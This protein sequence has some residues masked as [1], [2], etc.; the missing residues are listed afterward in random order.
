VTPGSDYSSYTNDQGLTPVTPSTQITTPSSMFSRKP[1]Y[2]S[3]SPSPP[4]PNFATNLDSAFPPF[5]SRYDGNGS[6]SGQQSFMR[7]PPS[8]GANVIQ[9]MNGVADGPFS[10]GVG[11]TLS[12]NPQNGPRIRRPS[13]ERYNPNGNWE[14]QD[15]NRQLSEPQSLQSQTSDYS[16]PS[17]ERK[18]SREKTQKAINSIDMFLQDMD[19]NTQPASMLA[20]E[21]RSNTFP[22]DANA[23]ARNP[24]GGY[25]SP[26]LSAAPNRAEFFSDAPPA[27]EEQRPTTSTMLSRSKTRGRFDAFKDPAVHN[28]FIPVSRQQPLSV[29]PPVQNGNQLKPVTEANSPDHDPKSPWFE[30][31][32]PSPLPPGVND[33]S[34]PSARAR[35]RTIARPNEPTAVERFLGNRQPAPALP[36]QTLR[37]EESSSRSDPSHSPSNSS[38]SYASSDLSTAPTSAGSLSRNV[39]S[40]SA[41]SRKRGISRPQRPDALPPPNVTTHIPQPLESPIDPAVHHLRQ[42]LDP[43]VQMASSST[44]P[45]SLLSDSP[46]RLRQGPRPEIYTH[47]PP[48]FQATVSKGEC[49]GCGTHIYGKSVKAAD[50]RLTGRYHKECFVCRTCQAPF[51]SAEFYVHENAPY[52]AQHY[53]ELN[54]SLCR[55]CNHGIEG[56]YLE[57]DRRGKFHAHCFCCSRCREKLDMDYYEVD[58][59]PYCERHALAIP[60]SRG[61]GAPVAEKRRTRMMFM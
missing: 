60:R 19:A 43:A 29:E 25:A 57:T 32:R 38:S 18:A 33:S 10:R 54:G 17:H 52:C 35:S 46:P 47:A 53:H 14:G 23:P 55:K 39:S 6:T 26:A 4:S 16:E 40:D 42:P 20:P 1:S 7:V 8:P 51:P 30:A 5:R 22:E 56:Q 2:P 21:Q 59:R 50:G 3:R 41:A 15:H 36:V 12:N 45:K 24:Y 27:Q 13:N 58:G 49:R 11:R 28:P 37:R 48:R 9:R 31:P 44:G 34:P 61:P